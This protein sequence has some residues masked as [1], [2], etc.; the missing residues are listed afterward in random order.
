ML[1]APIPP[2]NTG[3]GVLYLEVVFGY[4]RWCKW[5]R[6]GGLHPPIDG[7]DVLILLVHPYD[8]PSMTSC[9]RGVL[10]GYLPLTTLDAV[11]CYLHCRCSTEVL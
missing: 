11:L 4:L 7:V 9:I 5:L 10:A 1:L 8:I 2:S 3:V 6:M